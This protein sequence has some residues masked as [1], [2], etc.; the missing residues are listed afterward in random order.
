MQHEEML[1]VGVLKNLNNIQLFS[2]A[3]VSPYVSLDAFAG[4]GQGYANEYVSDAAEGA[5]LVQVGLRPALGVDICLWKS[6]VCGIEFGYGIS[7]TSSANSSGEHSG[8][9][10]VEI[11]DFEISL[12]NNPSVSL[13]LGFAF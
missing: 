11:S 5:L 9:A 1:S 3:N 10:D 13:K 12:G 4:L 6:I 8:T 7:Y 2:F